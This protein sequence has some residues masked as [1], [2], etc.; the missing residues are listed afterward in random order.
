MSLPQPYKGAVAVLRVMTD[1]GSAIGP[2]PDG[3]RRRRA[4]RGGRAAT[5]KIC[6]G[7][8][9]RNDAHSGGS[10]TRAQ[11]DRR[12]HGVSTAHRQRRRSRGCERASRRIACPT[13]PLT[14]DVPGPSRPS[15]PNL[16]AR[17]CRP[18]CVS[19][20]LPERALASRPP[21]PPVYRSSAALSSEPVLGRHPSRELAPLQQI[22]CARGDTSFPPRESC[23][24]P[25]HDRLHE[26]RAERRV[27][28]P[29]FRQHGRPSC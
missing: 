24:L 23:R 2:D 22:P 19:E 6:V 26:R 29:H 11:P 9:A 16:A 28:P 15:S 12:A 7:E 17:T 13:V 3:L 1:F 14:M 21:P 5:W 20:R 4:T 18:C 27:A 8:E 10:R 25:L